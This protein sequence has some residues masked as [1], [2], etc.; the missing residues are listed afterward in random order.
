MATKKSTPLFQLGD[1]V[2]IHY[3]D[4]RGRIVE[5]RGPLGP[6]GKFV[7]RIRIPDKP[8]P[9]YIELPEDEMTALP[10]RPKKET[11]SSV[12]QASGTSGN[13]GNDSALPEATTTPLPLFRAGDRVKIRDSN[14]RGRVIELRIPTS[15]GRGYVYRVRVPAEPRSIYLEIPENYL[16]A[17]PKTAK[18]KTSSSARRRVR[19]G[20]KEK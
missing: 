8:K 1:R 12:N 4:W 3:S 19:D 11:S 10:P 2:K 5:F 14:W 20:H 17:I 13:Q 9:I 18:K 16:V 7:Y 6:G 15:P